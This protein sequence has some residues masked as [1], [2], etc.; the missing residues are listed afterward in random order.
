MQLFIQ[1]VFQIERT[2]MKTTE[3]HISSQFKEENWIL[4][5]LKGLRKYFKRSEKIKNDFFVMQR[6]GDTLRIESKGLAGGY[7]EIHIDK[8]AIRKT[9]RTLKREECSPW[10]YCGLSASSLRY[11]RIGQCMAAILRRRDDRL[12]IEMVQGGRGSISF[13]YQQSEVYQKVA[14]INLERS[15]LELFSEEELVERKIEAEVFTAWAL[16]HPYGYVDK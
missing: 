13:G 10:M 8:A 1:V 14:L 12:S 5:S 7:G 2:P 4:K 15:A 6:L 3:K 9:F 16:E 11:A